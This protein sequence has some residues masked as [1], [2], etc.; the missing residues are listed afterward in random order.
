MTV[1]KK[2]MNLTLPKTVKRRMINLPLP[3][4]VKRKTVNLLLPKTAKRKT[5]NLLLPKTVKRKKMKPKP[6]NFTS[7]MIFL[8][9]LIKMSKMKMLEKIT[10]E[11]K[12]MAK[13]MNTCILSKT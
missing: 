5:V 3:K 7:N 4:T 10:T 2:K 1:K 12:M 13:L 6:N 11:D 9:R 8:T